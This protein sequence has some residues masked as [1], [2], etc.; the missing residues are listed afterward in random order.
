MVLPWSG[1][2]DADSLHSSIVDSVQT[3]LYTAAKVAVYFSFAFHTETASMLSMTVVA[4]AVASI[5]IAYIVGDSGE[6]IPE[7]VGYSSLR[8]FHMTMYLGHQGELIATR[9]P[10]LAFVLVELVY[11]MYILIAYIRRLRRLKI[12]TKLAMRTVVLMSISTMSFVTWF[13]FVILGIDG[14]GYLVSHPAVLVETTCLLLM[15][16]GD[17]AFYSFCCQSTCDPCC[18]KIVYGSDVSL[19]ALTETVEL[20]TPRDMAETATSVQ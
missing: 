8:N 20:F 5:A 18:A 4:L 14:I 16:V 6:H 13:A 2:A 1:F 10:L 19:D 12:M 7:E 3:L 17:S 11:L 9:I 15:L